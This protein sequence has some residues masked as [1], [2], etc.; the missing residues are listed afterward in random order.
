MFEEMT[1]ANVVEAIIRP[2]CRTHHKSFAEAKI[3]LQATG[4]PTYFVSH[5]W[6]SLF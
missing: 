4:P 2:V 1:T 5:A 3:Q 6:D